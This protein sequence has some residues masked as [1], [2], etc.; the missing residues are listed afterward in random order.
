MAEGSKKPRMRRRASGPP[1]PTSPDP[2]E[3]AMQTSAAQGA[4][5]DVARDLLE[6]QSRLI[7]ADLVYRGWQITTER[8][9]AALRALITLAVLALLILLL[10]MV[11]SASQSRNVVI[12]PFDVPGVRISHALVS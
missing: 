7:D 11:W 9:T 6:R 10:L 5:G 3:I 2:V 1:H 12:E 8:V 4:A